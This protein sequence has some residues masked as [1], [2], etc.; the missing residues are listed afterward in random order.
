VLAFTRA[1]G[2]D[3]ASST[4]VGISPT[5]RTLAATLGARYVAADG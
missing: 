3:P 1:H 2:I 4:L 5:H